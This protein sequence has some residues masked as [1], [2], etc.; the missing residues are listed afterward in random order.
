MQVSERWRCAVCGAEGYASSCGVCGVEQWASSRLA[1][2][3]MAYVGVESLS[4]APPVGPSEEK[5]E[6]LW[7]VLTGGVSVEVVGLVHS[8]GGRKS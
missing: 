3:L 5:L 2:M 6:R 8:G 1:E 7:E 4:D